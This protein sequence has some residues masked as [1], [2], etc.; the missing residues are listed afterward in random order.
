MA[1]DMVG[2]VIFEK[3]I[4][5]SD[6][7]EVYPNPF[8]DELKIFNV[9]ENEKI[10]LKIYSMVGQLVYEKMFN[11]D[12]SQIHLNTSTLKSGLYIISIESESL[13]LTFKIIKE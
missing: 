2:S 7:F 3:T 12:Q 11:G 6:D 10:M 9:V 8:K 5:V 1:S 13:I 4:F